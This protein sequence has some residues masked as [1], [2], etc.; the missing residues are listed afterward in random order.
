VFCVALG[1]AFPWVIE[2]LLEPAVSA[3]MIG[4]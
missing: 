2:Y 1:L 3:I 4:A